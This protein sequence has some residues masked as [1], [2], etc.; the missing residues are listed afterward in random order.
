MRGDNTWSETVVFN[1]VR[2]SCVPSLF[3]T[4]SLGFGLI[5]GAANNSI[6]EIMASPPYT[7]IRMTSW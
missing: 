7:C 2:N 5:S 6:G 1:T 4:E 3:S